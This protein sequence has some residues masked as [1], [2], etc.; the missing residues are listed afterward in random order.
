[1]PSAGRRQP[2]AKEPDLNGWM[3]DALSRLTKRSLV[4]PKKTQSSRPKPKHFVFTT[5]YIVVFRPSRGRIES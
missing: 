4:L 1:V 3:I 2:C 5:G